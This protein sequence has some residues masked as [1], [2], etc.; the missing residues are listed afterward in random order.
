MYLFICLFIYWFIY[1]YIHIYRYIRNDHHW[2]G[3]SSLL[4]QAWKTW[5]CQ[6]L[7]S[8]LTLRSCVADAVVNTWKVAEFW[9]NIP[10]R[11]SE[12]HVFFWIWDGK[13]AMDQYLYIPF[14]GGWTSIYQLFWCS[15]G[16]QGFDTLPNLGWT[17]AFSSLSKPWCSQDGKRAFGEIPSH[18]QF[19]ARWKKSS[20]TAAVLFALLRGGLGAVQL[21]RGGLDSP[22]NWGEILGF[23]SPKNRQSHRFWVGRNSTVLSIR[24]GAVFFL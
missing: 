6:A 22:K 23:Q 11:G 1:I 19:S 4:N 5:L 24:H 2:M 10:I 12:S 15:P 7:D 20:A 21:I 13:M 9:W 18:S 17:L 3:G 8:C 16:V 14:L